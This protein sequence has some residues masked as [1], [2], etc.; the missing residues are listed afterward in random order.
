MPLFLFV[1]RLKLF[2]YHHLLQIRGCFSDS[3]DRFN[4]KKKQLQKRIH[5]SFVLYYQIKL[6]PFYVESHALPNV[7]RQFHQLLMWKL[8]GQ[9]SVHLKPGTRSAELEVADICEI[10]GVLRLIQIVDLLVPLALFRKCLL[11]LKDFEFGF[12]FRVFSFDF[13]GWLS[14]LNSFLVIVVFVDVLHRFH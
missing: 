3:V 7:E 12:I 4:F 10:E 11:R 14:I 1:E 13:C 5:H 8:I 9:L 2:G 6:L